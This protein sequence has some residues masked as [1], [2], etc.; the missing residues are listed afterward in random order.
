M[1]GPTQTDDHRG[2]Q[3]G[4]GQRGQKRG[5]QRRHQHRRSDSADAPEQVQPQHRARAVTARSGGDTE[6]RGGHH[7]AQAAAIERHRQHRNG[8]RAA[9]AACDAQRADAESECDQ[10]PV[11]ELFCEH[12]H[13]RGAY[14]SDE[15]GHEEEA[16]LRIIQM[17]AGFESGHQRPEHGGRDPGQDRPE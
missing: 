5:L 12:A 2:A 15:L 14:R 3:K 10:A 7:Y 17:P 9:G 11:A 1:T 8:P 13:G 4:H 16:A 6:V